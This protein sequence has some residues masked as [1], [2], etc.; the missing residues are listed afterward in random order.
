MSKMNFKPF[1]YIAFISIL[2]LSLNSCSSKYCKPEQEIF[3]LSHQ[4]KPIPMDSLTTVKSALAYLNDSYC[5]HATLAL[6][7]I[8]FDTEIGEIVEKPNRNTLTIGIEPTPCYDD[9]QYDFNNILEIQLDGKN[10]MIEGFRY[11]EDSIPA[12]IRKQYLNYGKEAGFSKSPNG[13]GIWL[14]T[15]WERSIKDLNPILAKI[16]QGYQEMAEYFSQ[17]VFG[18]SLCDL[19]QQEQLILQKRL[20]FHLSLKFS[21]DIQPVI[22]NE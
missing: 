10:L 22:T 19:D 15:E 16:I 20:E 12:F 2:G 17:S 3:T 4:L 6:P 7:C 14:I 21:D 11:E 1:L 9:L 8:Y 5:V 13:N 18:K